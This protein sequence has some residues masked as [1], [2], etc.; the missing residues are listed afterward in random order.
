MDDINNPNDDDEEA[1][2]DINDLNLENKNEDNFEKQSNGYK[3]VTQNLFEN[4]ER[5]KNKKR[6]KNPDNSIH[7]IYKEEDKNDIDDVEE[8]IREK[9][10]KYILSII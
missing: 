5:K 2:G 4:K 8:K 9:K 3:E 7:D 10:R 1:E 6:V